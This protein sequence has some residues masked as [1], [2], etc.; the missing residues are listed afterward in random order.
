[1]TGPQRAVTVLAQAGRQAARPVLALRAELHPLVRANDNDTA[2]GGGPTGPPTRTRGRLRLP[3]VKP[4]AYSRPGR[5]ASP[6][7]TRQLTSRAKQTQ[8]THRAFSTRSRLSKPDM[9]SASVG[10]GALPKDQYLDRRSMTRRIR[11]PQEPGQPSCIHSAVAPAMPNSPD[12][13]PRTLRCVPAL[14]DSL[15]KKPSCV[16][17]WKRC[18]HSSAPRCGSPVPGDHSRKGTVNLRSCWT[19]C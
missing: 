19:L 14:A 4:M 3:G 10:F 16:T 15:K 6:A 8:R 1:M 18:P 9:L 12:Y 5:A 11:K 7:R 17:G 2:G 13:A